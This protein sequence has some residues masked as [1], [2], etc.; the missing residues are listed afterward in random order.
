L[1][2]IVDGAAHFLE[3]QQKVIVAAVDPAALDEPVA[4]REMIAARPSSPWLKSRT[5]AVR[6]V[7]LVLAG[8]GS[9]P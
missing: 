3:P 7:G 1:P 5:A 2:R 6:M 4:Q 9:R 8:R